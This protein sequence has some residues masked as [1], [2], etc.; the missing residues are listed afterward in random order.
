MQKING[1]IQLSASDLV[2]HL[3]C[4]HLTN[5]ELAAANGSLARPIVRDPL[6]DILVCGEPAQNRRIVIAGCGVFASIAAGTA[7]HID[8]LV[9]VGP[10]VVLLDRAVQAF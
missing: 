6:Q 5:L 7:I 10:D 9:V 8:V 1:S 2:A 3:N 4:Q